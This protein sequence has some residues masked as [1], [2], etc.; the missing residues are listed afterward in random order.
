MV[1]LATPAPSP[2]ARSLL[3][4]Y[5]GMFLYESDA[6][7]A[8]RRAAALSL[9]STLLAELLGSEAIRELLDPEVLAEVEASLQRLAPDRHARDAEGAADLLRFLGDLTTAEAA[10]RGVRPEW[11]DELEAARRAIRV[12]IGGEERWLAIEDAGRV[13][14]ALGAA[15]PVGVPEAFTE[16]VAGSAGRPG[17]ALRPHARAVPGGRV[18]R[19]VRARGGGGGRRAGPAGRRGPAGPRRAAPAR[20]PAELGAGGPAARWVEYCDAE[21]LRRLR[22]ALA[23]PAAGRGRAGRAARAGPV[24]ARLA[25]RADRRPRAGGGAGCAAHRAPRTCS[26]W[27]SSWPGRRCRPAR[28]SR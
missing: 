2:F 8:E 28:W 14:D 20:A 17:A 13:R 16:P 3:F 10:D 25:G 6:P 9:D 18:R 19:P 12:R 15:L 23:G 1:E 27:W 11:L 24:P 26:A 21:V 22:R 7:L 5:V 4:G